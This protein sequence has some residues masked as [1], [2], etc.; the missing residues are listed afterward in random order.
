M[1]TETEAVL[2]DGRRVRM[3]DTGG[4]DSGHRLTVFWHH[5]TP[6]VG[7]PPA[8]LFPAADRLGIRWVSY[9]RPGYGGSTARPGRVV[10]SVADDV[11]QVAD[12]LG[13]GRFAVMGHSGGA[14]HALACGALLPDRVLAVAG[15]AGLAPFGAEGLD[16]FAGMSASGRASLRAAARGRAAKEEHEA[17]AVYDPEMFTPADHAALSGTWSWFGDVV[18]PAVES[19]PGPL[20]DDDL[21]YVAPWGFTPGQVG[22]PVLLLHG[23]QDRVAPS[24]HSGWL[25]RHLP[26]AELRLS[27]QDGHLSVLD[28]ADAA[29][30][31]LVDNSAPA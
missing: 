25:A 22:V 30:A 21:A 17:G 27:P 23:E 3:Y 2:A 11:A 9:D 10:A 29:L 16:W 28:S 20:V 18:G 24:A 26:A 7:S 1:I 8:P 31:W 12:A 19:G 14:P 13:V 4:P 5:G 15:V 6:N